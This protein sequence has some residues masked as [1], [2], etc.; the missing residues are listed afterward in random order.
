MKKIIAVFVAIAICVM[1]GLYGFFSYQQNDKQ[2]KQS[3][4]D[5]ENCYNK[6]IY[7]VELAS[8]INEAIENNE[9]FEVSKDEEGMYID[10]DE[11]SIK[12]EIHIT[13][14]DYTYEMETFSNSGI[15]K[16]VENYNLIKFKCTQIQYHTTTGRIKYLY[17]EQQTN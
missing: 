1:A 2:I 4:L 6:E 11:T 16:F 17:F 7:G 12:I 5:Y 9:K 13:D 10:N 3:N 8:I 15:N 14:N